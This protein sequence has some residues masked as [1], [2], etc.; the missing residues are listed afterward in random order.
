MKVK[1]LQICTPEYECYT[2]KP[3][4]ARLIVL[5]NI[6]KLIVIKKIQLT[7]N[8]APCCKP[9]WVLAFP[10]IKYIKC[11]TEEMKIIKAADAL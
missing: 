4:Y 7:M 1:K 3:L 6:H 8:N 5:T 2:D 10:K 9:Y 11:S